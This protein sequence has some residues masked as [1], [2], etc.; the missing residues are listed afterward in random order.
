VSEGRTRQPQRNRPETVLIHET[1]EAY[2]AN[3][4]GSSERLQSALLRTRAHDRNIHRAPDRA[5]RGE[6]ILFN[7][8]DFMIRFLN[9]KIK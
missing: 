3:T 1:R 2:S 6:I 8:P 9:A 7:F 5:H 4:Q